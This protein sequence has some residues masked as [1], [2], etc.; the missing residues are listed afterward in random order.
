MYQQ[1]HSNWC[2]CKS[3]KRYSKSDILTYVLNEGG[4]RPPRPKIIAD[5]GYKFSEYNN[6]S[7]QKNEE[8]TP[9]PDIILKTILKNR[10][11]C[12]ETVSVCS[13]RKQQQPETR[14]P[15]NR[16]KIR[17]CRP[18]KKSNSKNDLNINFKVNME[19][20]ND[21]TCKCQIPAPIVIKKC[22]CKKQIEANKTTKEVDSQ[23]SSCKC[24]I[25]GPIII[26]D[27][28]PEITEKKPRPFLQNIK[29]ML[30]NRIS[31][32]LC[33]KTVQ[34]KSCGQGNNDQVQYLFKNNSEVAY[35]DCSH[36]HL[37]DNRNCY[38]E[39]PQVYTE[40]CCQC[41]EKRL[42]CYCSQSKRTNSIC[43]CQNKRK[44]KRKEENREANVKESIRESAKTKSKLSSKSES[45]STKLKS[46]SGQNKRNSQENKDPPLDK[47]DGIMGNYD[48]RPPSIS[49]DPQKKSKSGKI[50]GTT[51]PEKTAN[52]KKEDITGSSNTKQ[53]TNLSERRRSSNRKKSDIKE[54]DT[55]KTKRPSN[56]PPETQ[57]SIKQS[58]AKL[59]KLSTQS[60]KSNLKQLYESDKTMYGS[61]QIEPNNIGFVF[62]RYWHPQFL[63]QISNSKTARNIKLE[64]SKNE[65][66]SLPYSSGHLY[67]LQI[68]IIV[69]YMVV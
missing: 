51:E 18:I 66:N 50:S 36:I 45:K 48:S 35:Y 6:V 19:T 46:L 53:P 32:Q 16:V 2:V 38:A 28:S 44:T 20:N 1:F 13:V 4:Y 5:N 23:K 12:L 17:T 42:P 69:Y 58:S 49:A 37:K 3:S 21:K 59:D 57:K 61:K 26:C 39:P 63:D 27:K 62:V 52:G 9:P 11:S 33:T 56:E 14:R 24:E 65:I 8:P 60:R 64:N 41:K 43:K 40:T 34:E 68:K 22:A 29:E 54:K 15:C 47:T 10:N 31:K 30:R 7:T 55:S 67:T 25:S